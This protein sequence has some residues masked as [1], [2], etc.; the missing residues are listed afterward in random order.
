MKKIF[1]MMLAL[2]MLF[3]LAGCGA[4]KSSAEDNEITALLD[5]GYENRMSSY[6]EDTWCAIFEKE[7]SYMLVCAPM[8]KQQEKA[9]EEMD[10]NDI[11][12]ERS[13]YAGF[14]NVTLEDLSDR[15]PTRE[16]LDGYVGMTLT[17]L[18]EQGFESMGWS[19][20]EDMNYT[21]YYEGSEYSLNVI[22]VDG[23]VIGDMDDWSRNALRA[24]EIGT[25]E[26]AG[27]SYWMLSEH[28]E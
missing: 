4:E 5:A 19:E 10:Y 13:F 12:D 2:A 20:N 15:V 9:H 25:V 28:L 22:P 21:F 17:E 18:E 24:L 3:A 1:A 6:S 7:G 16:T 27:F 14:E 23:T 26:F 8:T 11:S